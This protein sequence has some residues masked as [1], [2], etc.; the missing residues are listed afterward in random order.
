MSP[1]AN[2]QADRFSKLM[3]IASAKGLRL[4]DTRAP[5]GE[6]N[7]YYLSRNERT[8]YESFELSQIDRF[9]TL[10]CKSDEE[11]AKLFEEAGGK[12]LWQVMGAEVQCFIT[13]PR[14][15]ALMRR[16]GGYV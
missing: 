11:I 16:T 1:R 15:I 5:R 14:L 10:R 3:Q 6:R 8:V 7:L 12:V 9:L 2:S 13:M 4:L